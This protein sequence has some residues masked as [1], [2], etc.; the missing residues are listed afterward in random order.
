MNKNLWKDTQNSS[1]WLLFYLLQLIKRYQQRFSKTFNNR[2]Y[3]YFYSKKPLLDSLFIKKRRLFIAFNT[4]CFFDH[5][6]SFFILNYFLYFL[7]QNVWMLAVI[8]YQFASAQFSK[9][10]LVNSYLKGLHFE[11]IKP[12]RASPSESY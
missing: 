12:Q 3:A 8:I 6:K 5:Q 2:R 11:K 1:H 9:T 10:L 7:L 4:C